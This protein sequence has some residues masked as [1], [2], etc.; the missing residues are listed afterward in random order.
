MKKIILLCLIMSSLF[1]H[2]SEG[3]WQKEAIYQALLVAD[4][5]QTR[6]IASSEDYYETN[7]LL[8]KTPSIA[9]VNKYFVSASLLHLG[10]TYLLPDE[11][12]GYWLK[13]TIL[14]QAAYVTNNAYIGIGFKF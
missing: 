2:M 1:A 14:I 10:I 13:S 12:K 11:Y 5:G 8:G 9:K 4:W 3:D 6:Y 7:P